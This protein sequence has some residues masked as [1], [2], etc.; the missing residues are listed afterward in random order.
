MWEAGLALTLMVQLTLNTELSIYI[1]LTKA[2]K[3]EEQQASSAKQLTVSPSLLWASQFS[4]PSTKDTS[5]ANRPR[6]H[7]KQVAGLSKP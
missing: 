1:R 7:L 3:P 2:R 4:V 6:C 5:L